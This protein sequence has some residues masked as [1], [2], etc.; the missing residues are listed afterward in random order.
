MLPSM[1]DPSPWRVISQGWLVWEETEEW[2]QEL[3][4]LVQTFDQLMCPLM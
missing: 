3:E 2:I 1:I 4:C